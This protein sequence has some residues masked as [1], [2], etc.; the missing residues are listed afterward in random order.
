MVNL[1]KHLLGEKGI[2]AKY[3]VGVWAY[4]RDL[5]MY[6]QRGRDDVV[7]QASGLAQWEPYPAGLLLC[8]QPWGRWEQLAQHSVP[9]CKL[10]MYINTSNLHY[11][12]ER[13]AVVFIPLNGCGN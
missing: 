13:Q 2:A 11:N 5:S 1:G 7:T 6:L 3:P 4:I 9:F 12:P 10:F 8:F